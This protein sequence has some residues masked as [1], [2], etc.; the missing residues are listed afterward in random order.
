MGTWTQQMGFPLVIVTRDGDTIKLY[1]K[2]FLMSPPRNETDALQPKSPFDY[3]WYIPVTYYTDKQPHEIRKVWLNMT[4][5]NT[6]DNYIDFFVY[7]YFLFF[8]AKKE[9]RVL[10]RAF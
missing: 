1:Q 7:I 3:R 4:T 10:R 8:L 5:G 2:R 6:Q 9:S